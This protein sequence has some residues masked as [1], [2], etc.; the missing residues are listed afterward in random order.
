MNPSRETS[1][2]DTRRERCPALRP[3][4]CHVGRGTELVVLEGR[5]RLR[6][7][8]ANPDG[9]DGGVHWQLQVLSAGESHRFAAAARAEL[10][11]LRGE[12]VV[13]VLSRAPFAPLR[14]LI[15][16]LGGWWRRH[17]RGRARSGPGGRDGNGQVAS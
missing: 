13:L 4:T 14:Q 10:Q 15:A 5:L 11:G 3:A 2:I 1:S 12:A 8:E 9:L 6:W 17:A 7:N 16:G